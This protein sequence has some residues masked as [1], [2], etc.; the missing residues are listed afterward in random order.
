MSENQQRIL[1][2][3]NSFG[4][5]GAE[6]SMSALHVA[7]INRGLNSTF[8]A[9]NNDP[10]YSR[11]MSSTELKRTW[12]GGPLNTLRAIHD[13]R[14]YLKTNTFDAIIANCE[15][16]EL[17][18]AASNFRPGRIICVEHTTRPWA[19]RRLLGR[20]VRKILDLYRA[21]WVSVVKS[22]LHVWSSL[23]TPRYIPNPFRDKPV[24]RTGME[25][26]LIYIGR[27]R[28]EKRPELV[29]RTAIDLKVPATIVGA[30][31]QQSDLMQKYAENKNISFLG[32]K[33]DPWLELKS[34][35]L[36]IVPSEYEGD[37]MVVVEAIINNFPILLADN[38]D[39]RRFDL[40]EGHYFRDQND[41]KNKVKIGLPDN[42]A[43][44]LVS[45]EKRDEIKRTR[46]FN[47]ILDQWLDLLN[48]ESK[49]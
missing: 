23:Q 46:E 38:A 13:F 4:G 17:F 21:E 49:F 16:A 5:G 42:F 22:Q 25:E 43:K 8:L 9:I 40:S 36:V 47:S 31:A 14:H 18:V 44:F 39:L 26:R 1:I 29:I 12:G 3:C 27:L 48:F 37:G 6:D 15:L 41:L 20:A 11:I 45:N 30:G 24:P 10:N 7:L 34:G 35:G 32:Y 2:L 33:S 28:Q 19:G